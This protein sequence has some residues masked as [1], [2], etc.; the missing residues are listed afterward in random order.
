[1]KNIQDQ[2]DQEFSQRGE[3]FGKPSI[4]RRAVR[5][6]MLTMNVGRGK[7]GQIGMQM[8]FEAVIRK[9]RADAVAQA[10]QRVQKA[11]E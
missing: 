6:A 3:Y 1:M 2:V 10:K 7:F 4:N 9:E 5:Y 11:R 8:L